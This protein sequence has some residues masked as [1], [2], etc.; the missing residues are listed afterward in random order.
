MIVDPRFK[1]I[2]S[3]MNIFQ[4]VMAYLISYYDLSW[5]WV[6][7]LTYVVG[8]TV[9]HSLMLSTHETCHNMAFGYSRPLAN[10]LF[11]IWA[12]LAILV[13]FSMS[14]RKYHLD[15]HKFQA[16]EVYD[17]DVP[18]ALEARFFDRP[19]TKMI[20]MFLQPV[21]YGLRPFF[22]HPKAVCKME[23]LNIIVQFI[24]DVF[25]IYTMGWK[26]TTYLFW[27]C[28]LGVGLHPVA[29]HFISEHYMFQLG[30]ETYSY[31]GP[32]NYIQFNVGYHNEHHDFPNIHG[33]YLPKVREMAPE[34]YNNLPHHDSML[35]V[36]WDFITD[37][38]VG[39][40]TR[41]KRK[42]HLYKRSKS[43]GGKN[44]NKSGELR[45][46]VKTD[47]HMTQ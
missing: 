17:P 30:F 19:L 6:L 18:T 4:F 37:P 32:L 5:K 44:E 9:G 35:K 27:G 14:F 16:H 3:A 1:Y 41:M 21:W 15:H 28:F 22:M 33:R 8:G 42:E 40:Y 11:G 45:E 46:R 34:Y 43:N 12:N 23:L 13:P 31:Y 36:Q 24:F 26:A 2:V 10:K 29:G 7:L 38:R 20:W 39:L 47:Y 25:Y